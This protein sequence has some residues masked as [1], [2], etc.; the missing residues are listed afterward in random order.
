[1]WEVAASVELNT[2][3]SE[4]AGNKI[5]FL[6][7]QLSFPGFIEFCVVAFGF[8]IVFLDEHWLDAAI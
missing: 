7:A 1:M 2:N 3:V 6:K 8:N 4:A 5:L